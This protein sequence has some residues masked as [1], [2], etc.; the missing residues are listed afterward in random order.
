MSTSAKTVTALIVVIAVI[1]IIALVVNS[2]KKTPQVVVETPIVQEPAPV[3]PPTLADEISA[4]DDSNE[5]LSTDM[6]SFDAEMKIMTAESASVESS[7]TQPA[8]IK[9]EKSIT[10]HITT[11]ND[12]IDILSKLD[13]VSDADK[14]TF[15][16][17]LEAHVTDLTDL[18][19]KITGS[20]DP[21]ALKTDIAS[22]VKL[23]PTY[24][25]VLPQA[26]IVAASDQVLEMVDMF[27]ALAVKL[28]ARIDAAKAS[29]VT[30]TTMA[31]AMTDLQKKTADAT[32]QAEAAIGHMLLVTPN[33][34]DATALAKN[35][36]E[37]TIGRANIKISNQDLTAA[38]KNAQAIVK[39][40]S[41]LKVSS[42]TSTSSTATTTTP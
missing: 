1:V 18:Q 7:F 10:S 11:L 6:A 17:N 32:K 13:K 28:Q 15:T 42:S 29:G 8:Q 4:R 24:L 39:T 25:I 40:L 37:L 9:D 34:T 12:L 38:Y 36:S 27:D 3:V 30:V 26:R 35:K 33:P 19:T 5:S 41:T 16:A 22:V 20:T 14:A 23:Y 2:S 21:A 31:A